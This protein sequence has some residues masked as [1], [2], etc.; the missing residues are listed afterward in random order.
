M[1]ICKIED[2]GRNHKAK[3]YC[4]KHYQRFKNHGDPFCMKL[5]RHGKMKTPEYITWQA[6]K[7]RCYDRKHNYYKR[8]GGRGII[9]CDNW[10]K[11]FM[12]FLKDMGQRPF[13]EAQI[14]RIDNNGNYEPGNCRWAGGVENCRHQSSTKL[15]TEKA[16]EIRK[17]YN[18]G[19]ITQK[20]LSS[21]YGVTQ[22]LISFVVNNKRWA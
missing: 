10:R 19:N 21:I 3:G 1:K 8:Y 16:I 22:G 7:S 5:E 11:S 2:C 9:I 18:I 15:T 14:D 17:R 13:P 6:M 20:T 4:S 12:T